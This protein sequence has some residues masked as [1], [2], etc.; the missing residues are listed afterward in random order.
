ML[1]L[2][3]PLQCAL[4]GRVVWVFAISVQCV[5]RSVWCAVCGV[6]FVICSAWSEVW[7]GLGV[8]RALIMFCSSFRRF[9]LVSFP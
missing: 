7:K 4:C 6:R 1:C 2:E 9:C 5:V 8:G 3:F